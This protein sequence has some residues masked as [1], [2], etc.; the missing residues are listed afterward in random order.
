MIIYIL[1]VLAAFLSL[2][3]A[4]TVSK[5]YGAYR[6]KKLRLQEGF[7]SL[8]AFI[9]N[10]LSCRCRSVSEWAAEFQNEALAEA[11]FLG[12]L[13]KTGSLYTAFSKI[14]EKTPTASHD[15]LKLLDS[16]FEAFGKSYRNEESAEACRV[17]DELCALTERERGEVSKQVRSVKVI[18]YA[19]S[20]GV[21]ILFL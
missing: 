15:A 1:K 2:A 14:K 8:L 20:L 6:E 5:E 16:Y 13:C 18:S 9:K 11:G 10:E 3:A 17:F 12:E 21:I 4:R 19:A 7:I